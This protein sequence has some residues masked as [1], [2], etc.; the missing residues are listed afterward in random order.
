MSKPEN[1]APADDEGLPSRNRRTFVHGLGAAVATGAAT[2]AA[3]GAKPNGLHPD[4]ELIRL[5]AEFDRLHAEWLSHLLEMQRMEQ[6]FEDEAKRRNL[7]CRRQFVAWMTLRKETGYEAA[8][9]V[10]DHALD[11]ID[12]VVKRIYS[13]SPATFAGVLLWAKAVRFSVHLG[14]PRIFPDDDLDPDFV[15]MKNFIDVIERFC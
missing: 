3:A 5:G 4:A 12:D 6:D 13:S 10:N 11:L 2:F 9:C 8:I 15:A 7:D 1:S 14:H